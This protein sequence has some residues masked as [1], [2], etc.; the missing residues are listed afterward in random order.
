MYSAATFEEFA[1]WKAYDDAQD[2]FCVINGEDTGAEYVDL[3][4][5][6][7]RYTGYKGKSAHRIWN[8]IYLEN[9]FR[10]V[11]L[12]KRDTVSRQSAKEKNMQFFHIYFFILRFIMLISPP[13]SFC[14]PL[15]SQELSWDS[16][17]SVATWWLLRNFGSTLSRE[18]DFWVSGTSNLLFTGFSLP[19]GKLART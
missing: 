17:V 18:K 1:L 2:N 3:L 7:E 16:V 8:S 15:P 9:C 14:V 6:P 5:N 19:G 11:D 4:L 12:P 13:L 10:Y